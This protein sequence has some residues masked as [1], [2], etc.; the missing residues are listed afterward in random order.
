MKRPAQIYKPS[1]RKLP[2]MLPEPHYPEHDDVI[3][4][5]G[6]GYIAF[7]RRQIY[8]ASSLAYQHVGLREEPDGRWLV[9]FM[10]LDL[11]HVSTTGFASL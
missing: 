2:D 10:S 1:P 9:T 6:G 3:A 11:G 8:V 4:V 7:R 5:N